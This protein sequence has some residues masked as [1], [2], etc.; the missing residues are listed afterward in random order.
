MVTP[1]PAQLDVPVWTSVATDPVG[2]DG[3]A[4]VAPGRTALTGDLES[5]RRTVTAWAAAGATH[6]LCEVP[7]G[8]DAI[9][10]MARWL[11]PEVG[12]VDFPRVVADAPPPRPWPGR[13]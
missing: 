12:M 7:A 4:H 10:A 13:Y 6:L 3:A 2:V 8:G 5:D 11:I 9:A 1:K